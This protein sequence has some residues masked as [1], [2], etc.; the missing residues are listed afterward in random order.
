M[1]F[2]GRAHSR[3][4]SGLGRH[5][6]CFIYQL[7]R[8]CWIGALGVAV[9]PSPSMAL[10]V[11]DFMGGLGIRLRSIFLLCRRDSFGVY[12]MALFVLDPRNFLGGSAQLGIFDHADEWSLG[13]GRGKPCRLARFPAKKALFS[14]SP[15]GAGGVPYLVGAGFLD[16]IRPV[17]GR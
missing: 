13:A 8:I 10:G 3:G 1:P 2:R 4:S 14:D 12:T 15:R 5:V 9:I 11:R 6:L 7:G 16:F 17:V